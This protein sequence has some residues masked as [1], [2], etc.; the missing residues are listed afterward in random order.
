MLGPYHPPSENDHNSV[1]TRLPHPLK[2]KFIQNQSFQVHNT[3]QSE[4][5]ITSVFK[6]T[7]SFQRKIS[8][9]SLFRTIKPSQS[10]ITKKSVLARPTH[11]LQDLC[12]PEDLNNECAVQSSMVL[13]RNGLFK[14][15]FQM[16]V[17]Y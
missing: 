13:L 5:S 17:S 1:S 9:I 3:L 6:T 10:G 4:L 8:E 2:V 16:K 14:A 15:I 12:L 7:T 11:P